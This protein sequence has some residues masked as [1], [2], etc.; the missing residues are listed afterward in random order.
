[1]GS[2]KVSINN[3]LTNPATYNAEWA[4]GADNTIDNAL[5]VKANNR[6]YEAKGIQSVGNYSFETGKAKHDIDFGIR[7]HEDYEI[8]S[9]GS[10]DTQYKTVMNRT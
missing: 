7:Y 6:K 1:L 5:L 8:V 3:I 4:I 10:M 2:S 9:N